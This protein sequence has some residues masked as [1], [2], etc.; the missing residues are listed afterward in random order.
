MMESNLLDHD[1]DDFEIVDG[2]VPIFFI[3][4]TER[5]STGSFLK[6]RR[7]SIVKGYQYA[8]YSHQLIVH[9]VPSTMGLMMG[10]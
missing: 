3:Q 5:P 8:H 10:P 1:D 7:K 2:L 9:S 4:G 6:L